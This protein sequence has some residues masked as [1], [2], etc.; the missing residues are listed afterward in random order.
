[1]RE[2]KGFALPIVIFLAL[3]VGISTYAVV[4]DKNSES[5]KTQTGPTG[6]QVK[7]WN[8]VVASLPSSDVYIDPVTKYRVEIPNGWVL[9]KSSAL[10]E[11]VP[12][13][14]TKKYFDEYPVAIISM[15]TISNFG[16]DFFSC[17]KISMEECLKPFANRSGAM[18]QMYITY[19][20]KKWSDDLIAN[21]VKDIHISSFTKYP[22]KNG[23]KMGV[24]NY[25]GAI[26][27][28]YIINIDAYV[29][30]KDDKDWEFSKAYLEEMQQILKTL[31]FSKFDPK[32]VVE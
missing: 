27:D 18:I 2:Q 25:S 31:D 14:I 5:K 12:F 23:L 20:G 22:D 15:A 10:S 13:S 17:S 9:K 4:K 19:N 8:E 29:F 26:N 16:I 28:H 6:E 1:M 32:I 7:E 11:T 21:S 24:A 3:M 30:S